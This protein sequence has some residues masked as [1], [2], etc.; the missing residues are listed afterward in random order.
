MLSACA[1]RADF[2]GPVL[3]SEGREKCRYVCYNRLSIKTDSRWM[4]TYGIQRV[5]REHE[6]ARRRATFI[7]NLPLN[8]VSWRELENNLLH[9]QHN[10]LRIN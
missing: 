4:Q 10:V 1:Y 9:F 8:A 2:Y 7:L 5:R 6:L 3:R